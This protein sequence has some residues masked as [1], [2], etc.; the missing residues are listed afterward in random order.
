MYTE[1]IGETFK[2]SEL[3]LVF[4]H[5][6][7]LFAFPAF[8]QFAFP[9]FLQFAFPA[10]LQFAFGPSCSKVFSYSGTFYCTLV[11]LHF[12]SLIYQI[13]KSKE[14]SGHT[15][16]NCELYYGRDFRYQA[17]I[18]ILNFLLRLVSDLAVCLMLFRVMF[19]N[20]SFGFSNIPY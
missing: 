7:L 12:G 9:A 1:L 2:L 11:P 14:L 18:S 6:F 20:F 15:K 4:H 3:Y 19:D 5:V 10:F 8:L 13:I 16:D 17:I